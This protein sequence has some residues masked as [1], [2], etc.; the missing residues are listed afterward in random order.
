MRRQIPFL[1]TTFVGVFMT[2][3]FFLKLHL[4]EN[5][6]NEIEQWG[7]IIIACAMVLGITNI[8]RINLLAIVR[9][10]PDWQY[11]VILLASFLI[12][13]VSGFV[14]FAVTGDIAGENVFNF[15]FLHIYLPLGSTMYALLAFYIASAAFRAFRAKNIEAT[16][17]LSAAILVMLGR[18]PLGMAISD[19]FPQVANWIMAVPN[20]AG[21]RGIIMGAAIGVIALGLKVILGIERPYLRGE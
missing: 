2:A 12:T 15:I 9:R 20:T 13:A 19:I 10:R 21:Q 14:V 3:K 11:K 4:V 1:I 8:F 17:M 6:A 16:L 18:V 7:V 5:I